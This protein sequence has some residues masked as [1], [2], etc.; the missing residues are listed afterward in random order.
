LANKQFDESLVRLIQ[1]ATMMATID[2]ALQ[3]AFERVAVK[4]IADGQELA[5]LSLRKSPM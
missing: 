5:R 3:V 2:H 1:F 4:V